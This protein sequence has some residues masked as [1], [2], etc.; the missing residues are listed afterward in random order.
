MNSK[1]S[2]QEVTSL[3]EHAVQKAREA[4]LSQEPNEIKP[5]ELGHQTRIIRGRMP[6]L[7]TVHDRFAKSFSQSLGKQLRRNFMVNRRAIELISQ[8]DLLDGTPSPSAVTVFGLAP[9]QGHA[10]L[11]FEQ[12]LVHAL[13]DLMFGG[14][15]QFEP[16]GP[17]KRTFTGIEMRMVAKIAQA[18]L[19]DLGTAWKPAVQL[20]PT[21]ERI[22]SNPK[23]ASVTG[24]EDI[25][26]VTTFDVELHRNPMTMRVALPYGM[27]DPIRARLDAASQNMDSDLNPMSAARLAESLRHT[28]VEVCAQLG[29]TSISLRHFLNLKPGEV[30]RLD[31]GVDAPL[32]V[33]VNGVLK[34]R[35]TQGALRGKTAV[36]IGEVVAPRE[37]YRDVL[38]G[39]DRD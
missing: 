37:R 9:L 32:P 1:F 16:G 5:Y 39:A 18:A 4:Q 15:G 35:G 2:N 30:L 22:E 6:G 17:V 8:K 27:L 38:D 25:L 29:R 14:T 20:R 21:F 23:L 12:R 3:L 7:E 19:Q 26:V 31:Q 24:P 10:I 11:S 28:S 33:L 34:F 36:R 13:I